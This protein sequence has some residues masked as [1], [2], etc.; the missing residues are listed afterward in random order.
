MS[1]KSKLGKRSQGRGR[2]VGGVEFGVPSRSFQL[3]SFSGQLC[4]L[5]YRKEIITAGD[6][7]LG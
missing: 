1:I 5:E 6:R 7:A 3:G 2:P 4:H